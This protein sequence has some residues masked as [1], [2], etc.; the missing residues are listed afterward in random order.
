MAVK[1]RERILSE[2]KAEAEKLRTEAQR[3]AEEARKRAALSLREKPLDAM[4][5]LGLDPKRLMEDALQSDDPVYQRL[6]A[7]ERALARPRCITSS[8][9][10]SASAGPVTLTRSA[11]ARPAIGSAPAPSTRTSARGSKPTVQT[12]AICPLWLPGWTKLPT[13]ISERPP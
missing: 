12:T 8:A 11:C 6:R 2:A 1:E 9:G 13:L 7:Y 3:E 10:G 4:R 5:E